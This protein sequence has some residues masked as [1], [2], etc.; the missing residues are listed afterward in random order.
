[1]TKYDAEMIMAQHPGVQVFQEDANGHKHTR[2]STR[3][4]ESAGGGG[5]GGVGGGGGGVGGVGGKAPPKS[6][7]MSKYN[8]RNSVSA[9]DDASSCSGSVDEE[10]ER[11]GGRGKNGH[12]PCRLNLSAHFEGLAPKRRCRQEK[13]NTVIS[14]LEEEDEVDTNVILRKRKVSKSVSETDSTSS[15]ENKAPRSGDST[16]TVLKTPERRLKLTLRMKRSP[17]LDEVIE[18]G[19]SLSEETP[20]G[21]GFVAPE[22][23]VLRVEGLLDEDEEHEEEEE[24]EEEGETTGE[25]HSD[26]TDTSPPAKR[27][28]RHKTKKRRDKHRRHHHTCPQVPQMPATSPPMKRLRLI[29]GNES[30]TINIPPPVEAPSVATEPTSPIATAVN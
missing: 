15:L 18:S 16:P 29:F 11:R 5:G 22:Y 9:V 7:K 4:Q 30:H 26:F 24:E 27:K 25:T 17:I 21:T 23:E 10:E 6:P 2:K 8:T 20:N 14:L 1:M 3:L 28:K 13:D 12:P 19:T